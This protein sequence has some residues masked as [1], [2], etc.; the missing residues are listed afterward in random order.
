MKN[1]GVSLLVILLCG[2]T[3]FAQTG[4]KRRFTVA[5]KSTIHTPSP[6]EPPGLT[7]IFSNLGKRT[8]AYASGSGW[9]VSGPLSTVSAVQFIGLP[10]TPAANA[11]VTEVRAA[12]SYNGSGTN[13]V[14]LSIYSNGTNGPGTLLS[15]PVTV[16]NLGRSGKCCALAIAD[17]TPGLAVT[18]GTQYWVV[19][20][21][22]ESGPGSDFFGTWNDVYGIYTIG[23]NLGSGWL[24]DVGSTP[25]PAGAVLGTVP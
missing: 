7:R 18:A 4:A 20:D 10:F 22:P 17:F 1:A 11:T 8:Q 25:D 3:L 9:I 24:Q 19:A 23:V 6:Q 14:N 2:A 13:Q 5:V 12:I 16:T 15:G 21:E